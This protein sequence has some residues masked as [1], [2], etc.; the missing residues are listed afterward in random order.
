MDNTNPPHAHGLAVRMVDVSKRFG[1]FTAVDRLSLTVNHGELFGF[2]GP[3]GAG[4]TTT[5]RM[6]MSITYPDSGTLSVLGRPRAIDVKDR[7]GYLPEE[8]G[9]YRKMTVEQTLR[10]FGKLKGIAGRDLT[11]LIDEHLG[12]LGLSEWKKKS[13][14]SLSKGMQQ[15]IQ[16][17]ATLLHDPDLIVLDEPF[18]GLDPLNRDMLE[19]LMIDLRKRG[20][21][22]IFSTHQM[23]QAERLCDRIALINRGRLLIDGPVSEIR[24]RFAARRVVLG[25]LG[26]FGWLNA[27]PGVR[28]LHVTPGGASLELAPDVEPEALLRR[29]VDQGTRL[30]HFEVQQ[31]SLQEIFVKLVGADV[32]SPDQRWSEPPVARPAEV[33]A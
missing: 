29:A 25:G 5:I 4:K 31:P 23:E 16:F 30:T 33:R 17:I 19:S 7:I 11:R 18:S 13:V 2:L 21:A 3:N 22:V 14:D 8:R 1:A 15:K 27:F 20:K 12:R 26:D 10:Y 32:Q 9:L 28:D 24:A 6:L